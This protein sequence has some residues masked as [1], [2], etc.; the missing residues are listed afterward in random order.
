MDAIVK[1]E[2]MS[3][4]LIAYVLHV[5]YV[6]SC[7][8]V[9]ICVHAVVICNFYSV[10][11]SIQCLIAVVVTP[12]STYVTVCFF[13]CVTVCVCLC[14]CVICAVCLCC[15]FVLCVCAVCLCCVFV[16]CVL[17]CLYCVFVLCCV[18]LGAKTTNPS[19]T[20]VFDCLLWSHLQRLLYMCIRV[21]NWSSGYLGYLHIHKNLSVRIPKWHYSE[22]SVIGFFIFK[23]TGLRFSIRRYLGICHRNQQFAHYSNTFLNVISAEMVYHIIGI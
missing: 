5:V 6:V 12:F 21:C 15:V 10:L 22:K 16:L 19:S 7:V 9:S 14:V 2:G 3:H 1:L 8:C 17:L 11:K 23:I 20:E 13:V 18:I 4:A